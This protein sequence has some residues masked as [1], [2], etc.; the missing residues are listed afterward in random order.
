MIRQLSLFY[1]ETKEELKTLRFWMKF[2][3]LVVLC[4]LSGFLQF[5]LE[6]LHRW[7]FPWEGDVTLNHINISFMSVCSHFT[8]LG[9]W[10]GQQ[11]LTL[12]LPHA[13]S[14][15]VSSL[16][17]AGRGRTK[18]SGYRAFKW[19]FS[20][21]DSTLSMVR[22]ITQNALQIN[23]KMDRKLINVFNF[24]IGHTNVNNRIILV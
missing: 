24:F 19:R 23:G 9:L 12:L 14:H 11:V 3:S 1:C 17:L 8:G 10:E 16:S 2:C 13:Y 15:G 4:S 5:F 6:G 20:E 22:D 21:A 18:C 7:W